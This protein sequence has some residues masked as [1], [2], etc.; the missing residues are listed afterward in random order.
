MK[1]LNIKL[2][3]AVSDPSGLR[4]LEHYYGIEFTR[5][6]SNGGGDNGYHKMIGD[7][8]LLREMRFHNQMKAAAI[9]DAMTISVLNQTN[10]NKTDKNEASII[11]GS[12]G[13]DIMVK[14]AVDV[15]AII[16]GTNPTYERYIVSDKPFSYDGDVAKLYPAYAET[17]DYSVLFE[18]KMR[19]F[20]NDTVAGTHAAGNG[21]QHTNPFFGT[22]DAGGFPRTSLSRYQ[23]EQY[24]RA[25][26][27]DPNS[28]LPYTNICNQDLELTQ[29][30]MF[31]EFRTKILTNCLGHGLSS[32]SAPT[33]ANW[34]KVTGF[35][36]TADNGA[37][38]AY[39]TMGDTIFLGDSTVA[40]SMWTVLNG[41]APILKMFEAQLAVSNGDNLDVIK[42]ADGNAVQGLSEG[43]M[44]GIWTKMFSFKVN[45]KLTAD[46]EKKDYTVEVCLRVPIWRGR[47]RLW[48]N[49]AQWYSGYEFL[50]TRD[51][52]GKTHH[53]LFRAP[54][55]AA[56]T[57]DSDNADK[58]MDQSF[59]FERTYE[60]VGEMPLMTGDAGFWAT[61]DHSINGITVPFVKTSGGAFGTYEQTHFYSA[62]NA[63]EGVKARRGSRFGGDAHGL[64]CVLRCAYGYYSPADATTGIGSGFRVELD[65]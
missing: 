46:G 56:L 43:V 4:K 63:T 49:C 3:S 57:I 42:D 64:G 52:D 48:G 60:E 29:A 27:P 7:E 11:N 61:A 23:Y 9:R 35:R 20:R 39:Q 36:L 16:G 30:F 14:H 32:N 26:N 5:G 22:A 19:S 59:A 21:T 8:S 6:A 34:G 54:S 10:W 50:K 28:N 31:I 25:K 2:P 65:D 53:K 33:A 45:A 12:D 13:S 62:G 15:Y 1:S 51:A 55:V 40:S 24:A 47:T 37:T 41:Y 38:Y 44:T 18:G 58:Q 17:P